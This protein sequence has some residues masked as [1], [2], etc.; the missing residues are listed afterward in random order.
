MS[1]GWD[2]DDGVEY[3]TYAPQFHFTGTIKRVTYVRAG[4]AIKDAEV[5]MRRAMT[6][7]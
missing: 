4:D 5:E 6:R 3:E 7:Q 1:C 2:Y